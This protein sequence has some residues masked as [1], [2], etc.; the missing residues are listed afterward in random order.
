MKGR[1][2]PVTAHLVTCAGQRMDASNKAV[3]AVL[4]RVADKLAL[5]ANW[6]AWERVAAVIAAG[7]QAELRRSKMVTRFILR[8][9]DDP[10]QH[11][12]HTGAE[13]YEAQGRKSSSRG[14]RWQRRSAKGY[15]GH[16]DQ[17]KRHADATIALRAC[18]NADRDR[19]LAHVERGRKLQGQ[20]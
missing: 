9:A 18:R 13:A 11:G 3:R 12:T 16:I 14:G 7:E 1:Y 17:K 15:K 19:L 10:G 6:V 20:C 4:E 5:D 2:R 8:E